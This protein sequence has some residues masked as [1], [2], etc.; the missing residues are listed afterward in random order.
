LRSE[1]AAVRECVN[2][3]RHTKSFLIEKLQYLS[4]QRL[5]SR[6]PIWTIDPGGNKLNYSARDRWK[7]VWNMAATLDRYFVE[8]PTSQ[9]TGFGLRLRKRVRLN[10]L[11]TTQDQGL[12]IR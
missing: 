10:R 9:Q 8:D 7:E 6:K 12:K 3:R 2:C 1:T 5:R 11:R 4:D